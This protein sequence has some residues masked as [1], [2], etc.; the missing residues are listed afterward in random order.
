METVINSGCQCA[1]A[2]HAISVWDIRI[3]E[4][5]L[6]KVKTKP[7]NVQIAY[8]IVVLREIISETAKAAV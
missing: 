7:V 3:E 1:G 6:P 8:N 4:Q 5:T 2:S